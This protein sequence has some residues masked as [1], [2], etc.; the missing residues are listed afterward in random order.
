M[1]GLPL[2]VPAV[3]IGMERCASL[4]HRHTDTPVC[5]AGITVPIWCYE[6]IFDTNRCRNTE[7]VDAH[8]LSR[9]IPHVD[10]V[11]HQNDTCRSEWSPRSQTGT[12]VYILRIP[13]T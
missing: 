9:W 2:V 4:F 7:Y 1:S 8:V 5:S 12:T 10:F 6:D 13:S 11:Q 3:F